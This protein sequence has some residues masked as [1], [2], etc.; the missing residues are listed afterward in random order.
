M[1]KDNLGDNP[2]FEEVN[3]HIEK[4]DLK[5]LQAKA[6]AAES[7]AK[8]ANAEV[9]AIPAAVCSAYRVV[10]PILRLIS[11]A[12]FLPGNWKTAVRIFMTFMNT[13]CP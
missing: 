13:L 8:S 11:G 2:T 12:F 6:S 9:I 10:R 4:A 3:A 7:A 5:D 1:Q